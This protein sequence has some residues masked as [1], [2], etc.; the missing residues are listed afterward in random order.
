MLENVIVGDLELGYE[1]CLRGYYCFVRIGLDWK[2]CFRG[3][4][5]NRIILSLVT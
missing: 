4:F 1:V 3:I 2:L 5:S